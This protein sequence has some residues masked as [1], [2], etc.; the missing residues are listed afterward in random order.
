MECFMYDQ[1]ESGEM[2]RCPGEGGGEWDSFKYPYCD[3]MEED[4]GTDPCFI[5]S[6]ISEYVDGG[7]WGDDKLKEINDDCGCECSTYSP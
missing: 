2:I 7:Y 3:T 1:D 5:R 6:H 4:G